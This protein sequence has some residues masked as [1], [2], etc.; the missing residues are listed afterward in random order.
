MRKVKNTCTKMA[1]CGLTSYWR[2]QRIRDVLPECEG[3]KVVKARRINLKQ[4]INGVEHKRC[5]VC[6][7]YKPLRMFY[8]LR[9]PKPNGKVYH[10]E[11]GPCKICQNEMARARYHEKKELKKKCGHCEKKRMRTEA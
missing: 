1:E 11:A 10:I 2:C 6:G 5:S 7:E 8:K 3:C 4:M 9:V